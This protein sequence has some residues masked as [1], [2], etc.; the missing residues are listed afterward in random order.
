MQT[1]ILDVLHFHTV[2][3]KS[4]GKQWR[5]SWEEEDDWETINSSGHTDNFP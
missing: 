3:I 1:V 4:A 2:K 5:F